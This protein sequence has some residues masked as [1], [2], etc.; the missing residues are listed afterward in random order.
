[1]PPKK[2][3]AKPTKRPAPV[4]ASVSVSAEG[5]G[6]DASDLTMQPP[7]SE[8][9]PSQQ[10]D[11]TADSTMMHIDPALGFAGDSIPPTEAAAPVARST[12]PTARA[13]GASMRKGE[14]GAGS[15]SQGQAAKGGETKPRIVFK[16]T[17]PVRKVKQENEMLASGPFA[18]GPSMANRGSAKNA[19]FIAADTLDDAST[20]IARPAGERKPMF[21]AQ[22][23]EYSDNEGG[24]R[25]DMEVVPEEMGES[26]PTGLI[27]ARSLKAAGVGAK[28]K[29]KEDKKP[30]IDNTLVK[31]EPTSPEQVPTQ[32][33]GKGK[34]KARVDDTLLDVDENMDLD[35]SGARLEDEPVSTQAI[36]QSDSEEEEEEEDMTGDF[37]AEEGMDNPE[38]RLYLFQF[39]EPFPKFLPNPA[40]SLARKI[41][42]L[43]AEAVAAAAAVKAEPKPEPKTNGIMKKNVSF[44]KEGDAKMDGDEGDGASDG[45]DKGTT[46]AAKEKER[47]KAAAREAKHAK[48]ESDARFK[49]IAEYEKREK[50]RKAEGRIGTLVVSKSGRVK[51]V[52][53][54]DIVMD[55]TPGVAASFIQQLVHLD[56]PTRQA[57]VLGEVHKSYILTPD[58]DR[59]LHELQLN[60]GK[61]PGEEVDPSIKEEAGLIKIDT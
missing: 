23:E 58:V 27:R 21:T 33:K 42:Q 34:G 31:P 9:Q 22:G 56:K 41:E 24:N 12:A 6:A 29:G 19:A 44:K 46:S 17:V 49:K 14:S 2:V 35:E 30:K 54:R 59:L 57:R 4:L 38:D 36:D 50:E 37:V 60:G 43:K 16:P 26:A 8:Q 20:R 13:I 47:E 51:M 61:V 18:M 52:L 32:S 25:I 15:S 7:A 28:K 10:Q 1:M 3:F 53:G 11:Q 40:T 48:A 39:P 45:D 55:V 5:S